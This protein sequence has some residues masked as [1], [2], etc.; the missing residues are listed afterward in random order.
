[1]QSG[2]L[3]LQGLHSEHDYTIVFSTIDLLGKPTLFLVP[4]QCYH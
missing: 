4:G 2:C 1:M 3:G